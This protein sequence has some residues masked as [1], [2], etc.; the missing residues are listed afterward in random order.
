MQREHQKVLEETPCSQVSPK[1]RRYLGHLVV[2]AMKATHYTNTGT[3]EFLL[4]EDNHHFYFMEMNARLQV[5]HT[6]TEEVSNVQLIK[7]Q[8]L[9]AENQ[10]LPFTQKDI[11]LDSYAL[12]CRINAEDPARGFMPTPGKIV[13]A[14]FPFGT[15]GVRIDSGV[16]QGSLISP[17]YD[18][19]IAKIIVHMPTKHQAVVKMA[20]VLQEFDIEGVK[21]N[22]QFLLDLVR[23]RHFQEGKFNNRYIETSFL[24][25]WMSKHDRK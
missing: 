1:E 13:K 19:M 24:K 23:D 5:E 12:E 2:K 21:T 14:N 7:D 17:Y 10:P 25:D 15:K 22:R 8:I 4:D 3:I 11:H 16:K 6:I 18:S 9:V 20:R